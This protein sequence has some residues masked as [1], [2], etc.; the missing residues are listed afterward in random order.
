MRIF[1]EL[2]EFIMNWKWKRWV[3]N[4]SNESIY[5][6]MCARMNRKEVVEMQRLIVEMCK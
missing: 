4:Y 6:V 3:E 5:G 1:K 2:N